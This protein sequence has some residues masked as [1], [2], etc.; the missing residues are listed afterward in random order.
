MDIINCDDVQNVINEFIID[1]SDLLSWRHTCS[2]NMNRKYFAIININNK[3]KKCHNVFQRKRGIPYIHDMFNIIAINSYMPTY[4]DNS[5]LVH[6]R[7]LTYL[8]CSRNNVITDV[9]LLHL[10]KLMHLKCNNMLSDISISGMTNLISLDLKDNKLVTDES[11]MNLTKL[12]HLI[13]GYKTHEISEASL[14]YLYSLVGK[15]RVILTD[16]TNKSIACLTNLTKLYIYDNKCIDNIPLPSLALLHAN[17]KLTNESIQLCTNLLHLCC[18]SNN[19]FT[20]E[21]LDKLPKLKVLKCG[22]NNK[23]TDYGLSKLPNLTYLDCGFNTNFTNNGFLS[24]TK[25]LSLSI[26]SNTNL[27]DIC[28]KYLN[29]LKML[30]CGANNKITTDGILQLTNLEELIC[31]YGRNNINLNDLKCLPKLNKV[32]GNYFH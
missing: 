23:F 19:N 14:A 17:Q 31:P 18:R 30:N 13:I 29:R 21:I 9:A 5:Y 16:I 26:S 10:T 1:L 4:F 6:F 24:I 20:D 3:W 25:L 27:T 22:I 15:E 12:Q 2:R 32:N 7:H 28:F 11:L 8:D